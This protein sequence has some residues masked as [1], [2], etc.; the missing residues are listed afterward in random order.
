MENP[1]N[2]NED[3]VRKY[4]KDVIDGKNP[5][6]PFPSNIK[7][8]KIPTKEEL[9][10]LI[11][12]KI[13]SE[14]SIDTIANDAILGKIPDIPFFHF[15]PP[16]SGFNSKKSIIIDPFINIAK[17]HLLSRGGTMMVMAQYPPPAP[18]APAML[19]WQGYNVRNGPPVPPLLPK[20]PIPLGNGKFLK[21]E[22]G[23]V[24]PEQADKELEAKLNPPVQSGNTI[25]AGTGVTVN[26]PQPGS[27]T[28]AQN[29]T[30]I[31]VAGGQTIT[32]RNNTKNNLDKNKC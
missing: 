32:D 8:P 30:S 3:T 1:Y 22:K 12:S 17:I 14:K 7:I 21:P 15:V 29:Q 24:S 31:S 16:T 10:T 28:P 23:A 25:L 13:P 4:V 18:P 20:F 27:L 6:S 26:I 2:I 19:I 11:A 9:N 5:Q